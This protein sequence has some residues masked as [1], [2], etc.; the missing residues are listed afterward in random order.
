MTDAAI[1]LAWFAGL[2][3]SGGLLCQWPWFA[4]TLQRLVKGVSVDWCDE[5]KGPMRW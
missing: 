3:L 1:Y 4:R 2:C 5:A